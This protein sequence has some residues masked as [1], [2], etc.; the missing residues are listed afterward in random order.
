MWPFITSSRAQRL[1]SVFPICTTLVID[2]LFFNFSLYHS[3]FLVCDAQ[4]FI[5]V[6]I[7]ATDILPT[8][9]TLLRRLRLGSGSP[10][11]SALGKMALCPFF[12]VPI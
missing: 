3:T 5:S 10:W 4:Q 1:V 2:R 6:L 7:N 8:Q 12:L 11:S 9:S